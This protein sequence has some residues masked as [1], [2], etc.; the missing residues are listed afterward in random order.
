MRNHYTDAINRDCRDAA[1]CIANA[2]DAGDQ[3]GYWEREAHAYTL[4]TI[5]ANPFGF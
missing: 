4:E 3:R 5:G 1:Q 2:A